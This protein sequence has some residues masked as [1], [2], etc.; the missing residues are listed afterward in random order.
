MSKE[1]PK[2]V[3]NNSLFSGIFPPAVLV[4]CE[5]SQ[6]RFLFL[7][8]YIENVPPIELLDRTPSEEIFRTLIL[9]IK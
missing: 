9:P 8:L 6:T 3:K 4:M 2:I 1:T 5:A 7:E